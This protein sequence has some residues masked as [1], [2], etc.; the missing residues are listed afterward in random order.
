MT[1]SSMTGFA[2]AQG[3]HG[4]LSWTWE[5]KS[6]NGKGFELRSRV[7]AGFEALDIEIRK[8]LGAKIS[9]GSINVALQTR[10]VGDAA[11]ISVNEA[12]LKALIAVAQKFENEYA[13]GGA[14][15]DGLLAIPGV[16]ENNAAAV[17]EDEQAS[18][19]AAVLKSFDDAVSGLV[20]ARQAEGAALQPVIADQI[21]QIE[22]LTGEASACAGTQPAAV[23]ER[24]LARVQDYL[25]DVSSLQP[26]RIA[27]EV[28]LLAAKADVREE[29]DRLTGHVA[30]A[31]DLLKQKDAVGRKFDF[32]AQEFN[33]EANTLCSK[34]QDME[35]TRIGLA[36][37]NVIGQFRE[38]I[39]N[40]E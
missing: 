1:I 13:L 32:L 8:R 22:T 18:R 16:V 7:P 34:S 33:R 10:A 4:N 36:L 27:Q 28:A 17:D 40:I 2:R 39:Q 35:L 15:V 12:A 37:K 6:V 5:L 30:A 3:Q 23:K 26:E 29:L 25:A 11:P 9:R 20:K 19:E 31:R 24:F 38:Q 21:D 14:R